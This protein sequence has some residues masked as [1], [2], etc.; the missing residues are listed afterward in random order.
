MLWKSIIIAKC[1]PYLLNTTFYF[2]YVN[3]T[4]NYIKNM[5]DN[6]TDQIKIYTQKWKGGE[7]K[8]K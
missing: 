3:E 8:K 1:G 6:V 4:V 2:C 7:D 5:C